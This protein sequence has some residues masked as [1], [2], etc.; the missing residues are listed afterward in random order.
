MKRVLSLLLRIFIDFVI[1]IVWLLAFFRSLFPKK[2][3]F[4]NLFAPPPYKTWATGVVAAFIELMLFAASDF[5]ILVCYRMAPGRATIVLAGN[6]L[7]AV[8]QPPANRDTG[9]VRSA[10]SGTA[11]IAMAGNAVEP[12]SNIDGIE[13]APRVNVGA[14]ANRGG[15]MPSAG[16]T[17]S[18]LEDHGG[19]VAGF[20][21]PVKHESIT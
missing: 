13:L 20:A 12:T 18:G 5:M 8:D 16:L 15:E 7:T 17:R 10:V 2:T 14:S 21:V 4:Q 3:N 6:D 9:S 19:G 11:T 1:F